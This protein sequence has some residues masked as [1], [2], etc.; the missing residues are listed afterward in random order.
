MWDPNWMPDL[1]GPSWQ[2][3]RLFND[4]AG[5]LEVESELYG[6]GHGSGALKLHPELYGQ[7]MGHIE[8]VLSR[9]RAGPLLFHSF[10]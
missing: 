5:A 6:Q 2:P 4:H 3:G 8:I 10:A 7:D 9:V 1:G